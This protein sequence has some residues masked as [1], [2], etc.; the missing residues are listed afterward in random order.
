[1]I[2]FE[3]Q[4]SVYDGYIRENMFMANLKDDLSKSEVDRIIKIKDYW[5][6]YEGYHWE[7]LPSQD[8]A[9]VT[10]NYCRAF[11]DKFVAFELGN[12]FSFQVHSDMRDKIVTKDGRTLYAFL[13]DVWK[14][15]DRY[16][17]C[18]EMGQ[19]KSVTGESWIQISFIP[20]EDLEDPFGEYPDGRIKI[21]LL[22]TQV[23]FPTFDPHQKG[24]LK[25]LKILY[26]Y[27]DSVTTIY[28]NKRKEWKTFKQTWT[29]DTVETIDGKNNR[30][31]V[32]NKYGFIPFVQINNF[33][34]ALRNTGK[35][36]LEDIIPI[37]VEYNMKESNISEIIDYHSAPVTILYGAK[38][39]ALEKGANKL[40]G[41]LPK[42]ARVENLQMQSDLG[43]ST[44]YIQGIKRAMCEVGGIPESTLGANLAI[45][46]TSGVA[47]QYMN[48][49]IIERTRVKK[50]QTETGLERVN[51]M[52]LTIATLEGLIYKEDSIPLNRF[53]WNEVTLLGTLPKDALMELQ[54][55]QLEMQLGL[56]SRVGA[57]K[58]LGKE[59][60]EE[61][62]KEIEAD[63]EDE[64]SDL[65]NLEKQGKINSGILNGN[66]SIE[67]VRKEIEG[68][69]GLPKATI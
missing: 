11:V 34:I 13:D 62:L 67:E 48:M 56:E 47:M 6:F 58:R 37:N 23:V 53:L 46:N 40:W 64:K 3:R 60:I 39:G 50:A 17:F 15:N 57:M 28:K 2:G 65:Q 55:I 68:S 29:K 41:G 49:P 19:I 33:P 9:E 69:N 61:L 12:G 52:V 8:G 25:E 1:M 36:D 10:I 24:V 31:V 14:D 66:T 16:L 26:M 43:A 32:P 7:K 30:V 63:K 22:P 51:K 20:P 42:D 38:V 4:K 5:N 45:S 18:T 44:N 59:N 54:Q 27:E 21:D 35:S